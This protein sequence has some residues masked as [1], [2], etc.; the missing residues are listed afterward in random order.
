MIINNIFK[1]FI[2]ELYL[3]QLCYNKV[4]FVFEIF[5][6]GARSPSFMDENDID[7]CGEQ[8][9]GIQELT[10]SG[11]R[12]QYLLGHYIR[13]KYPDLINY[14]KYNPKDIE[15]K[16]TI[17]NRTIMSARAQLNGIFNNS[18]IK[19]KNPE[20]LNI[21]KPYYL[22]NNNIINKNNISFYPNE[23]PEE[24]PIHIIDFEE[25]LDYLE[26]NNQCP[27]I[28]KLRNKN[29]NRKEFKSFLQKYN[30]TFGEHLLNYYNI[31]NN[32]DYFTIFD[33]VNQLSSN[34]LCQ[35]FDNRN[36]KL[37]GNN[38]EKLKLFYNLS[39]E[40]MNLKMIF[41]YANDETNDLA[42]ASS[43][44]LIRKILLYMER[45]INDIN[46]NINDSPKLVLFSSHDS[47]LSSLQGIINIL[48]QIEIK[49]PN[50]AA[51]YI[52]ELNKE[53]N[54]YHVNIIFNNIIVKA[55]NF[56]YFKDKIK[57]DSW[58]FKKTGKICGFIKNKSNY[59]EYIWL[60]ITVISSEINSVIIGIIIFILIKIIKTK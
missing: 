11:L 28:Y 45:I 40:F 56:T 16:A 30:Q 8:W 25:K 19:I 12:Q 7:L 46:N 10:N 33:N 27:I 15:V 31:T 17:K 39:Q 58:T 44:I 6:H 21:G 59:N 3:F 37:F 41:F 4:I 2:I 43:S 38:Q 5:R 50:F 1:L 34:A 51:S 24:I 57:N 55:I 9:N 35:Q 26:K 47:T 53:N 18:K 32:T 13:N 22:I 14:E 49:P 23:Y 52:F 36:I 48:F 42:Y 54:E 29:K 60:M 20:K